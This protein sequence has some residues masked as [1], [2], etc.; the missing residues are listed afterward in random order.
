MSD[1]MN[2][3]LCNIL[4]PKAFVFFLSI[5]SQ[6][7]TPET[8]R[9]LEWIYGFEVVLA[10]GCWFIILAVLIS[11]PVFTELYQKSRV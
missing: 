10:V 7:V 8:S 9:R 5:F 11:L 1:F 4:N 3:F 2:G 6:F